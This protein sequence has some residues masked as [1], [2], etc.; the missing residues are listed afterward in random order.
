MLG[1]HA[2]AVS[3]NPFLSIHLLKDDLTDICRQGGCTQIAFMPIVL[4]CREIEDLIPDRAR[5]VF[6]VSLQ[7]RVT[8]LVVALDANDNVF[9]R[10]IDGVDLFRFG[11]DS[12]PADYRPWA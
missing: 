6:E 4:Q 9:D 3:F 2:W 8:L 11:A 12:R 5:G 10:N 7:T 1:K